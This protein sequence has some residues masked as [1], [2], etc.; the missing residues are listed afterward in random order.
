MSNQNPFYE[1]NQNKAAVQTEYFSGANAK[2]Y[3]GDVWV[4]QLA[5]LQYQVQETATPIY[6]FN[7]Y[8]YD[9]VARGTRM[10]TGTFTLN[11]TEVGYLQSI[12]DRLS[13]N[14][15]TRNNNLLFDEVANRVEVDTQQNTS[16]RNIENLLSTTGTTYDSY[17]NQM[18]ESYWG[19]GGTRASS[20]RT[21]MS[22]EYNTHYYADK[23]GGERNLLKDHGF[24]IL[25]D[26]SPSA[27]ARDFQD[28]LND[29]NKK[30]SVY[31][32]LKS[33]MGVQIVGESQELSPDGNVLMVHYNFIARDVDGDVRE[34][35]MKHSAFFDTTTIERDNESIE[36]DNEPTVPTGPFG[37]RGG[38]Y[39]E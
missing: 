23:P 28:C 3:F 24:N 17:I 27:N 29:A 6:G 18:K 21:G 8:L 22:R 12:L 38:V 1:Y 30:G 14:M 13:S 32:T 4:D 19:R 26:Y 20:Q 7:S 34:L 16:S 9:K 2:V 37:L 31:Q 36:R 15:G 39:R 33:I 35:S 25:I 5:T 11:F 10:I